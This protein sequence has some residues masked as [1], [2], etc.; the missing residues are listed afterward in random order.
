MDRILL[1]QGSGGLVQTLLANDLI[2]EFRLTVFPLLLGRGK[3]LFGE[4][5]MPAGLKL[6]RTRTSPSGVVMTTYAR[7]GDVTTGSFGDDNPSAAEIVRRRKIE[8]EG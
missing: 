2:D 1:I 7:A 5:T 8:E 4:G 3:R 6:V